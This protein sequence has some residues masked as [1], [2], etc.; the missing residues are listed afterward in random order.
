VE[1]GG[2]EVVPWKVVTRRWCACRG[3][4]WP[5]PEVVR[6]PWKV[7]RWCHCRGSH[8]RVF[9]LQLEAQCAWCNSN[10]LLPRARVSNTQT[11]PGPG[12][13]TPHRLHRESTSPPK[14]PFSVFFGNVSKPSVQS[15]IQINCC[16]QSQ[17]IERPHSTGAWLANT[18]QATGCTVKVLHH[19]SSHCRVFFEMS[20]SPVC[21][22]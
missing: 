22:V 12:W 7:R 10:K 15:V 4:R 11:R 18:T 9:F 2:P 21:G 20:R 16:P 19:Q 3:K 17:G 6:P 13:Q 14:L 8:S 5:R 1:S